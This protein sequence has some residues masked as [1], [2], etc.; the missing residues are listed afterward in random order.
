MAAVQ[1]SGAFMYATGGRVGPFQDGSGNLWAILGDASVHLVA[2]KSSDAGATWGTSYASTAT[3]A[4]YAIDAL[5][6]GSDAIYVA[7]AAG[8]PQ[9]LKIYKFTISTTTWSEVYTSGTRPTL[10]TDV[11]SHFPIFLTLRSTGE[12]VVFYQGPTHSLMGTAY[13]AVYYARCSS[14][15]VW[16]A[17]VEVSGAVKL[18][19]YD[20]RGAVLG[21]SDRV[22]M[23]YNDG[24]SPLDRSINSSNTLDTAGGTFGGYDAAEM[25]TSYYNATLGKIVI[26]LHNP[27]GS[28]AEVW[29]ASS[30][31]TPTF[32]MDTNSAGAI[33]RDNNDAVAAFIYEPTGAKL[34]VFYRDATSNDVY[35]NSTGTTTWTTASAAVQDVCTAVTGIS[36]GLITNAIG[37]VFNDTNV[38]F[39][40][41]VLAGGSTYTKAG[42]GRE[43]A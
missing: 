4:G 24:V 7:T 21:A 11:G 15:G 31:A 30:G 6:D 38:Y 32:T 42:Y 22:H 34:Y 26:G 1:I 14:A 17:G 35:Q 9:T 2:F 39:D 43:A 19:H 33:D 36:V 25:W 13:R 18:H 20:C 23:F 27:N 12:F 10:G 5:F 29:R 37:V 8:S 41:L 28:T 40:K 3:D 16:S